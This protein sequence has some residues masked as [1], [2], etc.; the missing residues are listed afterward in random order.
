KIITAESQNTL[1]INEKAVFEHEGKSYV[2]VNKDG[3]AKMTQIEKGLESEEQIEVIKGL[4]EG[5]EVILS[6]DESIEEGNKIQ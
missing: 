3:T 5:E 6:P 4:Q 1:L 2:F